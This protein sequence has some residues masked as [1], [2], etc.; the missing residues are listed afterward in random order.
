M[1]PQVLLHFRLIITIRAIKP[2]DFLIRYMPHRHMPPQQLFPLRHKTTKFTLKPL[3]ILLIRMMRQLVALQMRAPLRLILAPIALKLER[4]LRIML[5]QNVRLQIILHETLKLAVR[6]HVPL[7]VLRIGVV[8]IHVRRQVV[9]ALGLERALLTMKP[10]DV[11][12]GRVL[13]DC[14]LLDGFFEQRLVAALRALEPVVAFV[15]RREA[16]FG[17]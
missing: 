6:T 3:N 13:V 9:L 11:F 12:G 16:V 5:I 2:L 15:I 1:H 8:H 10:L 17:L 14:V 7:L 4:L